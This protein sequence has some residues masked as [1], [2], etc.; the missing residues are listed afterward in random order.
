MDDQQK[1]DGHAGHHSNKNPDN[2]VTVKPKFRLFP[3]GYFANND[4]AILLFGLAILCAGVIIPTTYVARV[5]CAGLCLVC[6][7]VLV[8]HGFVNRNVPTDEEIDDQFRRSTDE[9][10][11]K[12]GSKIEGATSRLHKAESRFDAIDQQ[13]AGRR[14]TPEQ[15]EFVVNHLRTQNAVFKFAINFSRASRDAS[16]YA[17][18]FAEAMKKAGW[19]NVNKFFDGREQFALEF[20]LNPEDHKAIPIAVRHL[21]AALIASGAISE[22]TGCHANVNVPPGVLGIYVG[23]AP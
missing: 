3:P 17:N 13:L 12:L 5:V 22:Q 7:V 19:E 1:E 20:S 10:L 18:G 15:I 4:W 23:M 14:L 9:S 8:I 6:C 21:F 2:K 11:A 16:Q